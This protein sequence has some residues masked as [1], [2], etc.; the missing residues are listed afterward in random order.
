MRKWI[1]SSTSNL[2]NFLD[3]R[4]CWAVSEQLEKAVVSGSGADTLGTLFSSQKEGPEN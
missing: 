3:I 2:V 1:F 4:E